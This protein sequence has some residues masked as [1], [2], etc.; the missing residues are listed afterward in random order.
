MNNV[1]RT[2]TPVLAEQPPEQNKMFSHRQPPFTERR[3]RTQQQLK[4]HLRTKRPT[5]VQT[6]IKAKQEANREQNYGRPP[7]TNKTPNRTGVSR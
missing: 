4:A 5:R 2:R 7:L 1:Q 6:F 3:R